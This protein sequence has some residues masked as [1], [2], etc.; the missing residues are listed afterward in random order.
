MRSVGILNRLAKDSAIYGVSTAMG[1]FVHLSL[2]PI[3]TRIFSPEDH[4][5]IASLIQSWQ[6]VS[7]I[8]VNNVSSGV[9]YHF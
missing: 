3:L 8:L 9:G 6:S 4:G 7:L 5:V 1:R 2:A